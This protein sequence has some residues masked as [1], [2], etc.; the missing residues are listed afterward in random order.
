M[1]GD[2]ISA[3]V[4]LFPERDVVVVQRGDD[5]GCGIELPAE[6][7]CGFG[8]VGEFP[9]ERCHLLGVASLVGGQAAALGDSIV[10]FGHDMNGSVHRGAADLGFLPEV[11]F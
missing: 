1:K 2:D 3:A 11:L 6:S 4:E 9:A 7:G 10:P 8:L 5:G